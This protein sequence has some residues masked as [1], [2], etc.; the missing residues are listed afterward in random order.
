MKSL[1]HHLPLYQS[2]TF[3]YHLGYY[4]ISV[5]FISRDFWCQKLTLNQYDKI[6][7]QP[8]IPSLRRPFT[9]YV[10]PENTLIQDKLLSYPENSYPQPRFHPNPKNSRTWCKSNCITKSTVTAKTKI[11]LV[12]GAAAVE[13]ISVST[14]CGCKFTFPRKT[15]HSFDPT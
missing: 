9:V 2:H 10:N 7:D 4:R 13:F 11:I 12:S 6:F 14:T 3:I 5:S 1:R 15:A 8:G